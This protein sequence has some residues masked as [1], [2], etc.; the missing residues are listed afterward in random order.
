MSKP[1]SRRTVLRALGASVSLPWLETLN[2]QEQLSE[3]PL[4]AAFLFM[5]NGVRPDY[6]T[7]PGDDDDYEFTPHLKPL[8]SLKSEFILCSRIS[9]TRTRSDVMAIGP[10]SPRGSP[11]DSSNA[12]PAAI[13]TRGGTSVD[14][15][16]AQRIG[17]QTP[18]PSFELGIDS[19]RT[20][21]DTAG[22]GFPRAL[23][24]IS[25][26]GAIRSTPVPKEIIPQLRSTDFSATP[27]SPARFQILD[28]LL[29]RADDA[30][31]SISAKSL[32]RNGSTA[33]R[34]RLDEYFESV[35]SV[36]RRIEAAMRPQKRW[37]NRRQ[38]SSGTSRRR[39]FR[40]PMPSTCG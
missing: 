9:G 14:Q 32:R 23:G 19:P 18:L 35:R 30:A 11:A 17:H 40:R 4:R 6:W 1:I 13:S 22:G 39:E 7:P 2:A 16:A 24:S 37:I 28:V 8:E 20:G 36:E 31:C 3:P 25:L 15:L 33:D 21:I 12:R 29:Q 34:L 38:V 10:K 27:D 5:P 26:L